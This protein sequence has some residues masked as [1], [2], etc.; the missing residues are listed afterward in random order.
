MA[1]GYSVDPMRWQQAF[2]ELMS[3]IAGRFARVEPR[4]HARALIAGLLSPLPSKNCRS[5]AE[6][7]GHAS[8]QAIQHVPER[9]RWDAAAV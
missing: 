4:R 3:R 7:A 2:E 6:H 1:A 5:I 9:A 8:P